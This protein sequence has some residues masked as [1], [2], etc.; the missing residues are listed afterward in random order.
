MVLLLLVI[1]VANPDLRHTAV[2]LASVP[3]L[4]IYPIIADR[5]GET[6]FCAAALLVTTALSFVTVSGVLW[7]LQSGHLL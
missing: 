4:S 3:M 5:Y 6:R 7:L 1:P 2:L